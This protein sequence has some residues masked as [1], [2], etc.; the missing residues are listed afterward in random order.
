[1]ATLPSRDELRARLRKYDAEQLPR[2]LVAIVL[3]ASAMLANGTLLRWLPRHG[4]PRELV[5][6]ILAAELSAM[7]GFLWYAARL[8][9]AAGLACP[10]CDRP[11]THSRARRVALSLG[12]C[13]SC[14]A[15]LA[16]DAAPRRTGG[17]E[18]AS[19]RSDRAKRAALIAHV[20]GMSA[21]LGVMPLV[22]AAEFFDGNGD[23]GSIA[24]NLIAHPGVT[25]FAELAVAIGAR[26]DVQ[27][28]LVGITD[29]MADDESSWPYSDTL[30]VITSAPAAAVREWLSELDPDE[31]RAGFAGDGDS[32][33][34]APALSPDMS[35]LRVWWD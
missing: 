28:V 4:L 21:P 2:F 23:D 13:A 11:F 22:T 8:A 24:A 31:V 14:G 1:M 6:L 19:D 10:N 17:T 20:K 34:G 30:Y 32:V 35:L 5:V 29:L 3:F 26:P 12:R 9:R 25:R 7:A 16:S 15:P 18:G 33:R 27:A